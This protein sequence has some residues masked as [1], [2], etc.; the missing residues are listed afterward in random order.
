MSKNDEEPRAEQWLR[1]QG[2][3]NIRDL[4]KTNEDP[5]DFVVDKRIGVEVRRLNFMT[6]VNGEMQGVEQ[7]EEPLEGIIRRKLKDAGEPPGAY[8]VSVSCDLLATSLPATKVTSKQ[9]GK[10]VDDYTDILNEAL[11]S[12]RAP[13]SWATQL[14]CRLDM[15]FHPFSTSGTGEFIL[16]QVEAAT[17]LRGWVVKDSIDTINRCIAYKTDKIKN[18]IHCYPEWW[19]VL[20]DRDVFTPSKRE[21]DEWQDIRNSLG[22]TKPWSRIVVLSWLH[23]STHVD[24]I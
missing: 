20:V 7:L 3:T 5:P 6:E 8:S 13:A 10:A 23:P 15:H 14:K 21:K 22:D 16:V 2:Y 12:G 9:V 1:S 19:L 18:L 4:S 11:Q 24:V 17:H